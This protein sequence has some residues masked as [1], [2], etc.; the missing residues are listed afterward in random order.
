M[1][2]SVVLKEKVEPE[3][4]AFIQLSCITSRAPTS[5]SSTCTCRSTEM[6]EYEYTCM[7]EARGVLVHIKVVMVLLV[8]LCIHVL[9]WGGHAYATAVGSLAYLV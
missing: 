7:R 2:H 8:L 5:K 3:R 1:T 9:K 4:V 6:Y